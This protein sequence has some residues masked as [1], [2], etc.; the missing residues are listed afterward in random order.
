MIEATR[1]QLRA[2]RWRNL[3]AQRLGDGRYDEQSASPVAIRMAKPL[4]WTVWRIFR[5]DKVSQR[6]GTGRFIFRE[7]V[8]LEVSRNKVRLASPVK[9]PIAC[10]LVVSPRYVPWRIEINRARSSGEGQFA[11]RTILQSDDTGIPATQSTNKSD[12][13][14][15]TCDSGWFLPVGSC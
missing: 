5:G 6:H 2:Q 12:T 8:E 4:S 1:G 11:L 3:F 10:S 9:N 15:T 7:L 14:Y 13:R